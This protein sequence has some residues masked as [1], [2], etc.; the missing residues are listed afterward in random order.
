M[1]TIL[2]VLLSMTALNTYGKSKIK[3]ACVG[4]SIT[5]GLKLEDPSRQSYPA[6]LQVML[7]Q[8]YEVGNFG[9]SGATLLNL[10]HR[11]YTKQEEYKK[12]IDFAAD[13]VVIH[14]GINDTD[15]RDW[16]CY[17]D[18]FVSDY[19]SLINDFKKANPKARIIIARLTPIGQSHSRFISGTR[20]WHDDIQN[21]IQIVAN[22]AHVEIVDFNA[23]LYSFPNLLPDAVHPNAEG[24]EI[25]ART[26]YQHITGNYGGL[27]LAE[28]YSDNMVLQRDVEMHIEGTANA[29]DMVTVRLE[30]HS[31]SA[32]VDNN[33]HWAINMPAMQAGGPYT[34][35]IASR[36]EKR[37]IEYKN[38]M[39]G[40]VWLCSG[41]SNMEF[42]L[43]QAI[44]ASKDIPLA[45]DDELRFYDM[46][47]RWRTDAVEWSK[48]AL[49]SV[50]HLQYFA[51]TEWATCT[52]ERAS[53]FSAIAYYFGRLLRD[54]LG[55]PVGL[56]CNAVGGSPTESWI[57]RCTVEHDFPQIFHDW[58]Q[59]DFVQ[60][61]VRQR[62]VQNMGI[63]A[64]QLQR[65]PY[66]P[67]YLFE[68]GIMPLAHYS[69][70]GCLWYQGESNA[71]NVEVHQQLFPLLVSSWRKYWKE[72]KLPIYY[73]QLSSLNRP[74]WTWFRDSQRRLMQQLHDVGMV[75]TSDVG[76]SLDVH[77]KNKKPVGQRLARWA[78]HDLYG[79]E[80]IVPSGPLAKRADFHQGEVLVR[81]EYGNN[82]KSSDGQS[83]RTFEVAEV[84]GLYHAAEAE[85]LD[86]GIVRVH[87]KEVST[88]HYVRYGWQPFTR[89]NLV[90]GD[91][92]PAST[93]RLAE[94][95][96]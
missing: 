16:P 76:D 71:H 15:P 79:Y 63:S 11:P 66:Q 46:K 65:H 81:F 36:K 21:A 73:V 89:A 69:L 47:A 20:D 13:I 88:P 95:E 29:G 45:T 72:E 35:T 24:A 67:C 3:V 17:R 85:V 28:I 37:T 68:A 60:D 6:R 70:R 51:S 59:N 96:K 61:W 26:V 34:L 12:A 42:M 49:D 82:L 57:D 52:P 14:L 23:P 31:V 32:S 55:V 80:N 92:L 22:Q 91:G 25:L 44:T 27:S 74:T 30:N 83:L 50:N 4:N 48:G 7:G 54:S 9:K 64:D 86:D 38:V 84:D 43:T 18:F 41:Q 39:V 78:L 2:A 5:Y 19:F 93:F 62:A 56:I 8:D 58:R 33:G 87:S 53:R 40:E 10:G 77:P 94:E 90:N 1:R 75:V